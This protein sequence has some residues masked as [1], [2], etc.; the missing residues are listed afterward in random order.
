MWGQK[1]FSLIELLIVVAIILVIAAIAIPN[2]L[3]AR[4]AANESSAAASLRAI[5]SAEITYFNTYPAIGYSAS[6]PDLGGAAPCVQTPA[7]ACLLD[8][9]LATAIPGSPGKSGYVFQVTGIANGGAI[10]SNYVTGGVPITPGS[11]GNRNFCSTSEQVLRIQTGVIGPP[12]NTLAA[13][14]AYPIAP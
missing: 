8:P 5:A 9:S 12:V 6:L 10:N 4:I 7:S 13:C 3:H 11:T 14:Y 1:G 2:M